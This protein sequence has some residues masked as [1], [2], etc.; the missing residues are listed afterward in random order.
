MVP[1]A[2]LSPQPKRQLY[3]LSRFAGLAIVTDGQ[4][5][6]PTDRP[7]Y[8][9]CNSR[10]HLRSIAMRPNNNKNRKT[11]FTPPSRRNCDGVSYCGCGHT[12]QQLSITQMLSQLVAASVGQQSH[13]ARR[14]SSAV[15]SRSHALSDRPEN[16][17][18]GARSDPVIRSF[19]CPH[20]VPL[21]RKPL[22]HHNW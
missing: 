18:I 9:V 7:R 8:S 21:R 11:L 12:L 6:R 2:H 16:S 1:W 13:T 17:Q 10:P 3:R 5:D 22:F 20:R 19:V 4:T 14:L 15:E